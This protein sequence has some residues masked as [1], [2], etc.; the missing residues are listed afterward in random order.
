VKRQTHAFGILFFICVGL[1][2]GQAVQPAISSQDLGIV[3]VNA[4]SPGT[5]TLNYQISGFSSKP[6]FLLEYNS[7]FSLGQVSC[8]TIA[9]TLPVS[10]SPRYPG[11]R[12]DAVRV[13]DSRNNLFATTFLHGIGSA[14]QA[15]VWPGTIT[16]F[17][18]T[19]AFSNPQGLAVDA[20]GNVYIADSLSEVI[21]RVNA[22]SGVMMT[23]AGTGSP[24]A[25]GDGG[26]ATG[27]SLNS[28][29]GVAVDGAGNLYIA[30]SENNRVRRVD[31]VSRTITT[32]AGNGS[33]GSAGDGGLAVNARLYHPNDV[34][35]DPA[36]NLYIA[37][38][39]NGRVRK[40]DLSGHIST[41]AGGG[42]GSRG[43][44]GLGDGGLAVDAL[45]VYPSGI[46]FDSAGS[47][48]IADTGDQLIRK[49][50]N[51]IISVAADQLS[52]P[53]SVRVDAGGNLYISDSGTAVV[54]VVNTAGGTSTIA[55]SSQLNSPAGIAIDASG[56]IYIAD[57]GNRMLRVI[58]P[59]TGA[60]TFPT[61]NVG[62]LSTPQVLT[63]ANIGNQSL[64]VNAFSLSGNFLQQS[65][66]TLDCL[67]GVAVAP[68]SA[69][70]VAIAFAPQSAGSLSGSLAFTT[71]SLNVSS[72]RTVNL[73][74]SATGAAASSPYLSA[75]T[76]VFGSQALGTPSS[77][78][79]LTLTNPG[80]APIT[81][82]SI[83]KSGLAIDEFEYSGLT[84][85]ATLAAHQSCSVTVVFLPT[86]SGQRTATIS[87][88][89]ST[90]SS[91]FA[92]S[93]FLTGT[94]VTP[95]PVVAPAN[96]TFTQAV[97]ITSTPQAITLS[98]PSPFPLSIYS[99][100]LSGPSDFSLTT[101]CG[102][103]LA[104]YSSCSVSVTFTPSAA[105]TESAQ[106]VFTTSASSSPQTAAI[107]G[108]GFAIAFA[109]FVIVNNHSGKALTVA[110]AS[111]SNA[112]GIQQT[113][114]QG[115][116]SQRWIFTPAGSGFYKIVNAWSGKALDVTNLSRSNGGIIQQWDY[117]GGDNQQWSLTSTSTSTYNVTNK[118]SG[119]VLDV[120][121]AATS[122]GAWIQQWDYLQ[123]D[124]QQWLLIPVQYYYFMNKHSALV[125]SVNGMSNSDGASV[126]QQS[127][128]GQDHQHWLF[129]P[130]PGGYGLL[131]KLSGK[132]LDVTGVSRSNGTPLQ[133]WDFL[134]NGNQLWNVFPLDDGG[135]AVVNSLSGKALDVTGVSTSIGAPIQ[136]WDYLG[137]DN[138]RWSLFPVT[139]CQI[140]NANS[141]LALTVPSLS[142]GGVITQTPYAGD[143]RQKW[144]LVPV[145]SQFYKIVDEISGKVLDVTGASTAN[146]AGV[147]QWDYLGFDNQLWQL[148]PVG[149]SYYVIVNKLSRRVLDVT[150]ASA[151]AGALIQQW[152][153][154]GG[155]NQ[156]WMVT[157]AP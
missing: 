133:Q 153:Y 107:S 93:V 127:Y 110:N 63:I 106:L 115:S 114:A 94:V 113:T 27:A 78:Q 112:A 126:N 119:K 156:M 11:L 79:T 23:V 37:D 140:T 120:T 116:V 147:Q 26:A 68:G 121:A 66:G 56:K 38:K 149:S 55:T 150:A 95:Q 111:S 105:G 82:T 102:A 1:A 131:N 137:G 72:S 98:N 141:G 60:L 83:V 16:D 103:T 12:V 152:D 81:V 28:P 104:A 5:A 52:Q 74:G 157:A 71:N 139:F 48:Y 145:D 32:V 122:D 51:G 89:E 59:F 22:T 14:S 9:C 40:V 61:T 117:L 17:A 135:S 84:C 73:S 41:F 4:S 92:Q 143:E 53:Q 138:Q 90:G 24:G 35:I 7:D 124:N 87:F 154:L 142:N 34:A 148:V 76:L 58:T 108:S 3:A 64:G 50:S 132:A 20:A 80:S 62:A 75:T 155:G 13:F 134:G 49:V 31:A 45:L 88:A 10:F 36:G 67:T 130:A 96:L 46:S 118:N 85:G 39:Y 21:R 47:L 42:S 128:L 146:G 99:I 97:G 8:S 151:S 29:T 77:P 86:A 54:R 136:Q 101:T 57:Q 30:D 123:G 65:A 15:L 19:G 91:H 43:T 6:S 129:L 69:C 100:T 109:E 144:Q 44:D 33:A 25:S 125:L 70:S 18:G 2:P